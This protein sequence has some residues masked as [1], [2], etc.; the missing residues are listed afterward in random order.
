MKM[1]KKGFTLIEL[2]AVIVILGI[3]MM[4]AIPAV[5]KAIAKSRRN[6]YWQN[7]KSYAKSA[8]TPFLDGEY[9]ATVGGESASCPIPG[10]GQYTIIPVSIVD[11]EQGDKTKSSFKSPYQTGINNCEPTIVVVNEGTAD[12]DKIEWYVLGMDKAGN[13]IVELTNI[14]ELNLSS[15]V[16]GKST[17]DCKAGALAS[18]GTIT[19]GGSPYTYS[20]T[21]SN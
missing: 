8:A 19:I 9:S 21:C 11:L 12:K 4:T 2:L 1:N 15:V 17:S 14:N 13:G 18:K 5:T 10:T 16:T 6:T 7:M 20:N 3:L